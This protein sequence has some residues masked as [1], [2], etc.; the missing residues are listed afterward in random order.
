MTEKENAVSGTIR[1]LHG[2]LKQSL[3]F[4]GCKEFKTEDNIGF[5]TVLYMTLII[6][7]A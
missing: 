1:I 6:P 2:H 5:R 4:P 7:F 3:Q